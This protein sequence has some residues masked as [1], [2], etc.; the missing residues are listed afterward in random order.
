MDQ[1]KIGQYIA[2]KRKAQG[3]TQAQLAELL[4]VGDKAVSKWERGLSLPDVS[5]YQELCKVLEVSLNELFAGEDLPAERV[6]TQAEQNFMGLA[7]IEKA[8]RRQLLKIIVL[9]VTCIIV[10]V[11]GYIANRNLAQ[12]DNDNRL[13]QLK[14]NITDADENYT[15]YTHD[16]EP[17][18]GVTVVDEAATVTKKSY[19]SLDGRTEI[20]VT[21]TNYDSYEAAVAEDDEY[22]YRSS[23]EF[24]DSELGEG[25]NRIICGI[26]K[27]GGAMAWICTDCG[28]Y[29]M[30]A[31]TMQFDD[32]YCEEEL[33]FFLSGISVD[34][35]LENE[36]YKTAR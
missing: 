28:I 35:T 2:I 15:H 36:V 12:E 4:G 34:E 31:R 1:K 19:V 9:L 27:S 22:M 18:I 20:S 13:A 26:L 21:L 25:I 8:K 14:Y 23:H 10:L 29:T 33:H 3:L 6:A 17:L 30:T 11:C 5:K 7:K 16:G 24:P 32:A